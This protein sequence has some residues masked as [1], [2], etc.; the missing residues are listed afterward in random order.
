[1][2]F[3]RYAE[4]RP[5]Y[6]DLIAGEFVLDGENRREVIFHAGRRASSIDPLKRA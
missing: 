6:H 3:P 2:I 4:N 1:M 5:Q